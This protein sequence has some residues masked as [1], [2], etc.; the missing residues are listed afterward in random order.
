MPESAGTRPRH[1]TGAILLS[2]VFGQN[3]EITGNLSPDLKD[4]C[5]IDPHIAGL[6][7]LADPGNKLWRRY[8]DR[9]QQVKEDCEKEIQEALS[10][11]L[12]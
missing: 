7:A 1:K 10:L 5:E 3:P 9:F 12:R 2:K 8:P 11:F 4:L 6:V